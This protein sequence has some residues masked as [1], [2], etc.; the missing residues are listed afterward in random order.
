M[1]EKIN[2]IYTEKLSLWREYLKGSK[3]AYSISH[4]RREGPNLFSKACVAL[5][6]SEIFCY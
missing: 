6:P 2:K 1:K 3:T 5:H 4:N